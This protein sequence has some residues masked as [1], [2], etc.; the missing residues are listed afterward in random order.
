M[1]EIRNE[2]TVLKIWATSACPECGEIGKPSHNYVLEAIETIYSVKKERRIRRI[3][4]NIVLLLRKITG[5]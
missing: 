3:N 5:N 4:V 2:V 1:E